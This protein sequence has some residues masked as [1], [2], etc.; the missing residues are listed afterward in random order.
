MSN[1][2]VRRVLANGHQHKRASSLLF[3]GVLLF[4]TLVIPGIAL[5]TQWAM[6]V[7]P[8]AAAKSTVQPLE[9]SAAERQ[10]LLP[11]HHSK[12]DFGASGDSGRH[13][14]ASSGLGADSIFT[15]LCIE[16]AN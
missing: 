16:T 10:T 11:Y 4:A 5:T 7:Q 6:D 8:S 12:I 1:A 9:L 15:G 3:A 13:C 2:A 14:S